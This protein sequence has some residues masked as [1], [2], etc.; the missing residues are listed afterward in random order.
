MISTIPPFLLIQLNSQSHKPF[1]DRDST[2]SLLK[3]CYHT[4]SS[5]VKLTTT[6]PQTHT[7]KNQSC[8]L[9]FNVFPVFVVASRLFF[10]LN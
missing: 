2:T 7:H 5:L 6:F 10:S 1:A 3:E 9:I 4:R 8:L